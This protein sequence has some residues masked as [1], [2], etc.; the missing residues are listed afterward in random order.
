MLSAKP[1]RKA[2]ITYIPTNDPVTEDV[3]AHLA[4]NLGTEWVKVAAELGVRRTAVA[5][6]ER[7]AQLEGRPIGLVKFQMLQMW[8]K[9]LAKSEDKVNAAVS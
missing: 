3:L 7:N 1:L 5:M 8:V 2:P 4:G 6:L 9:K